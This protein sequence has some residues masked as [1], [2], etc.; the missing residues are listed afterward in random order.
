MRYSS[1]IGICE[2]TVELSQPEAKGKG[3]IYEREQL[4]GSGEIHAQI[5]QNLVSEAFL[6]A[7]YNHKK[8]RFNF[9]LSGKPMNCNSLIR[10]FLQNNLN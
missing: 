7:M 10:P 9:K 8:A 3:R 4:A 1:S 5:E 6:V 2:Q